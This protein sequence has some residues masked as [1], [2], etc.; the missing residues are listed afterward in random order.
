MKIICGF[1]ISLSFLLTSCNTF[2]TETQNW[3]ENSNIKSS[4]KLQ[5]HY[6]PVENG[7]VKTFL[8][9]GFELYSIE[10]YRV[11]LDSIMT[12]N[13]VRNEIKRLENMRDMKGSFN[14]FFD[15]YTG[16]TYTINTL[17]YM[18]FN[19]N[20]AKMLLSIIKHN[21]NKTSLTANFNFKKITAAFA[22]NK[23]F[24]MFKSIFQ[25]DNLKKD[26]K[27]FSSSYIISANK[28]TFM[29]NLTTPIQVNFDGFI[30][31]MKF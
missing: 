21:N 16:S 19:R 29:I 27:A 9:V 12:K 1:L 18:N 15:P 24:T 13:E 28:R 3:I 23:D 20:D 7:A 5:G 14:L 10:K 8:P 6:F 11:T 17:P 25:I 31:K 2:I 30:E 4:E 26:T 22:K